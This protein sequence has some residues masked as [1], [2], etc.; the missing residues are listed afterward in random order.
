LTELGIERRDKRATTQDL[1]RKPG[2]F[3]PGHKPAVTRTAGIHN[4]LTRD[5]KRGIIDA[6][7]AYGADGKGKDGLTGYLFHLAGKHPKAFAGLLGKILPMQVTG[8]VGQFIGTV[9]VISVPVDHYLSP[10]DIA[11]LAPQLAIEHEAASEQDEAAPEQENNAADLNGE[12]S[13][14]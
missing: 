13:Q 1:E 8:N 5:L 7:E 9:N 2:T 12:S 14:D 6:A 11:R 4:R 10:D 3:L